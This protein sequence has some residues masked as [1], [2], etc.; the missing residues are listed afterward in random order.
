MSLRAIVAALGG[1]LYQGGARANVPA[2]GH[3]AADRSVSLLLA[4]GRVVIHGFGATDWRVV[5]DGLREAG[6]IDA[7]GRPTGANLPAASSPRPD[8]RHRIETA[9]R[10]WAASAPL[11]GHDAASL[12]LRRRAVRGIRSALDL[13]FHPRAPVSVYRSGSRMRPALVARIS[14]PEG[15]LCAVELTYLEPN[16]GLAIGLALVRKTVGVVPAGAAVRLGRVASEMIVGEGVVTT[17]SAIDRFAH[18]GWALMSANNLAAW[19][20]PPQVRRVLIAADRGA[21]GEGA[22]ARLGAR[23]ARLHV[24]SRVIVP[25][26]P[27]DDWNAVACGRPE[28]GEEGR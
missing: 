18:P 15:R 21:T 11:D 19:A 7:S 2:P 20:P 14:D 25:E 23:L 17:L 24:A 13:G 3:S 12:H 28:S 16:G 26:A 27:F 22:A 6:L 5:R 10:L 1:D 8:R 4:D 9:A